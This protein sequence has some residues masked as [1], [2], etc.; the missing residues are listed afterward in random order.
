MKLNNKGISLI[1][2]IITVLLISIVMIFMYQL[3]SDVTF[4]QDNDYI[5]T[6]NHEIRI[7]I[8]DEIE[9]SLQTNKVNQFTSDFINIKIN[10]HDFINIINNNSIKVNAQNWTIKNSTFGKIVCGGVSSMA[11]TDKKLVQCVIPVYTNNTNNQEGNNNTLDDIIFS[12]YTGQEVD[13]PDLKYTIYYIGDNSICEDQTDIASNSS[14]RICNKIA[15]NNYITSKGYFVGWYTQ[16]N[17]QGSL[18]STEITVTNE[19]VYLYA[20]YKSTS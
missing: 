5:A 16:D 9:K 19:N 14:V 8:I 11:S 13:V 7:E 4:E 18:I 1:E 6:L 12:F 10:D 2:L 17:C 3:F 15:P 20:C